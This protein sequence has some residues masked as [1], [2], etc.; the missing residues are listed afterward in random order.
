MVSLKRGIVEPAAQQEAR[1]L[2]LACAHIGTSLRERGVAGDSTL[3]GGSFFTCRA[4]GA[5][6][7]SPEGDA[8]QSLRH[9]VRGVLPLRTC[10]DMPIGSSTELS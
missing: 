7:Q 2:D 5:R 3:S 4:I 10:A 9:A 6:P 1:R 8:C